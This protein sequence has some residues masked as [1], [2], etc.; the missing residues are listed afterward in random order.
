[1]NGG[2]CSGMPS[3]IESPPSSALL[4]FSFT[5][6]CRLD[7][8]IDVSHVRKAARGSTNKGSL[9]SWQYFDYVLC[10]VPDNSRSP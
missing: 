3:G 5:M 6:K 10:D 9:H 2:S 8:V 1:V 7:V 4:A